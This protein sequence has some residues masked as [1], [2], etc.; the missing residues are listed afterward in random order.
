[1]KKDVGREQYANEIGV[2][3]S[4]SYERWYRSRS[5]SW[6]A[7][8]ITAHAHMSA[9]QRERFFFNSNMQVIRITNC[10]NFLYFSTILHVRKILYL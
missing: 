10:I 1:M 2:Y 7:R 5:R 3:N 9:H 4:R 8:A 6:W